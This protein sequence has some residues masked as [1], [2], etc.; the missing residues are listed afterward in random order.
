[1]TE[2]GAL[3]LLFA[4]GMEGNPRWL[5][6]P[7][8]VRPSIN[9]GPSGPVRNTLFRGKLVNHL[10]LPRSLKGLALLLS[11]SAS[12]HF[13]KCA[14]HQME[15]VRT[16][17][18]VV[19]VESFIWCFIVDLEHIFINLAPFGIAVLPLRQLRPK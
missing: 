18:K 11:V 19:L 17:S 8:S 4:A 14:V 2:V 9:C 3:P 13:L 15:L 7:A 16:L 5:I 12:Q 1:M 6:D 10:A